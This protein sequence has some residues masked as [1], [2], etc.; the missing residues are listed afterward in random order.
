LN[1]QNIEAVNEAYPAILKDFSSGDKNYFSKNFGIT[2]DSEV[3][4]IAKEDIAK[5]AYSDLFYVFVDKN[6]KPFAW[7]YETNINSIN[8][9]RRAEK[10]T[11]KSAAG[12]SDKI[13]GI[14]R[15]PNVKQL[16]DNRYKEKTDNIERD[17]LVNRIKNLL[18]SHSEEL[19]KKV[20][21]LKNEYIDLTTKSLETLEER[22]VD[23]DLYGDSYILGKKY[24]KHNNEESLKRISE[25]EKM[26][27]KIG[28]IFWSGNNNSYYTNK[29]EDVIKFSKIVMDVLKN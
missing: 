29:P 23:G 17:V 12:Y 22:I 1:E 28:H 24:G 4:E 9:G 6:G 16:I 15:D 3:I 10:F 5:K 19:L 8:G 2:A 14:K 7:G 25:I 18:D 26:I 20:A 11:R 21:E 27:G 13:Y